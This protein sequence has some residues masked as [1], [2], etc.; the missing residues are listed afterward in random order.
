MASFRDTLA[1]LREHRLAWERDVTVL[2]DEFEAL[3]VQLAMDSAAADQPS[4][5]GAQEERWHE[6]ASQNAALAASHSSAADQ[7]TGMRA[8]IEQQTELLAAFVGAATQLT[9]PVKPARPRTTA[10]PVTSAVKA[11]FAQL[12]RP[13]VPLAPLPLPRTEPSWRLKNMVPA[14]QSWRGFRSLERLVKRAAAIVPRRRA[15]SPTEP[16]PEIPLTPSPEVLADDDSGDGQAELV[17]RFLNLGRVAIL[18]RPAIAETIGDTHLATV[19]ARLQRDMAR[20]PE[21]EVELVDWSSEVDECRGEL[22]HRESVT[23]FLLDR[24]P[25]T[26]QQFREFVT[27]GGYEQQALW[28]PTI[29]PRVAEFV[30]LTGSVGPRFWSGGE[31]PS[32]MADCPVIGVCWYEADAYARWAGKRLPSDAEWVKAA[33]CPTE[34]NGGLLQRRFPWGDVLDPTR[35]NL[36]VSGRGR[37]AAIHEFGAGAS[38]QGVEQLVGNVWEWTSTDLRVS[39]YGKEARFEPGLKSIRGGAFDTYFEQLATCQLHS[40]DVP[41]ARRHNT[42]FRC[43]LSAAEVSSPEI[44]S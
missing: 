35:A 26:N 31:F 15:A 12:Q 30:D 4:N 5:H 1:S 36:W 10:D 39:I 13:P 17:Q 43:A 18:L 33:A 9:G 27:Q 19:H 8:M 7:L 32:G 21:G 2:F 42:G 44:T 34:G 16:T 3:A 22:T 6:L 41:L 11:E 38:A 28:D 23:P 37:P 40:G 25:V 14:L 20:I 29:W 24:H